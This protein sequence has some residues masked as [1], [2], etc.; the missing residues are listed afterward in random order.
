MYSYSLDHKPLE[1]SQQNEISI[2]NVN[3]P[4]DATKYRE[5]KT[6]QPTRQNYKNGD[7]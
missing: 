1:K 4:Y 6:P 5:L 7:P 2:A 3:A